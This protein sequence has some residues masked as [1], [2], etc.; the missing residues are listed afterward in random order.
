MADPLDDLLHHKHRVSTDLLGALRSED[1]ER[2]RSVAMERNHPDRVRAIGLLVAARAPG[3]DL[4]L[5]RILR[6]GQ[7][8]R[9][10]RAAAASELGRLGPGPDAVG[11]LLGSLLEIE[12]PGI[13]IQI[14][15]ALARVGT[16][17]AMEPLGRVA[18]RSEGAL[19]LQAEFARSVIA[20]RHDV[21]GY[22]FPPV[23]PREALALDSERAQAFGF[24]RAP[25]AEALV[26]LA[27]LGSDTYGLLP[28]PEL[29]HV[30][31]CGPARML[32][33]LNPEA[34]GGDAKSGPAT[35]PFVL[36]LIADRS[37]EDGSYS[38]RWLMLSWPD[39]KS[40]QVN[41]AVHRPSGDRI[42]SGALKT[43]AK[44]GT[45]ELRSVRRPGGVPILL[46][47]RLAGRDVAVSEALSE[48]VATTRRSPTPS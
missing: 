34:L 1:L 9:G 12:D 2:V 18:E 35:R 15:G 44:G 29:S 16:P 28:E 13:R 39:G 30:I 6:D 22:D 33:A 40:S 10:I 48:Q 8:D 47:G 7:E 11:M 32:V 19:K 36:G 3:T 20:C 42:L 4:L 24:E 26:A 46:R 25:L 45:F 17:D 5:A 38:M 41:L 27:H 23:S 43:G 37:Q 21:R 14:A 31:L